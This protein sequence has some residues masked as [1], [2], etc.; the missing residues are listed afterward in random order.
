AQLSAQQADA[1]CLEMETMPASGYRLI[2]KRR[3]YATKALSEERRV[4]RGGAVPRDR[5]TSGRQPWRD[6]Q[7]LHYRGWIAAARW[8]QDRQH[9]RDEDHRH[10]GFS[11]W[12]RRAK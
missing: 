12:R 1:A 4:N 8:R 6:E 7:G 5:T 3:R 11:R 10:Q 9:A 2:P